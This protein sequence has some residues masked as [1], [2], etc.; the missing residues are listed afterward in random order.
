MGAST[1]KKALVHIDVS[2]TPTAFGEVK[3]FSLDT[4]LGT[5]DASVISTDWKNYLVGQASWS[6][7]LECFYDPTDSAQAELSS[8]VI[9]G[10]AVTLT[11]YPL[12]DATGKPELT[13]TAYVTAWNVSGATE[14]AVGLSIS[15]QGSGAL[16][17]STVV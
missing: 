3:S 9:A 4:S 13:G 17:E 14:D 8:K 12:G 10:T 5:I 1:A 11:F 15:F 2:G 7:S 16:T 6:G